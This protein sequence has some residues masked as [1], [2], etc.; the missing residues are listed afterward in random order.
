MVMGIK[1]FTGVIPTLRS[2]VNLATPKE[3]KVLGQDMDVQQQKRTPQ[4]IL[5][6]KIG[7]NIERV[8]YSLNIFLYIIINYSQIPI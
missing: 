8:N 3:R 1:G 7:E 5:P 6:V 2:R 4:N